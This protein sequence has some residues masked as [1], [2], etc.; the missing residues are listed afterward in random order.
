MIFIYLFVHSFIFVT[1]QMK[2]SFLP[3]FILFF[4]RINFYCKVINTMAAQGEKRKRDD[5]EVI[6]PAVKT[7]TKKTIRAA[8]VS[9][10][11]S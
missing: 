9:Y 2:F 1:L 8:P 4:F 6:G 5:K 7:N 11:H 3:F 10:L